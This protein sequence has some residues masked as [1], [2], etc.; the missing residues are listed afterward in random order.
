[1]KATAVYMRVSTHDQSLASQRPDVERWLAANDVEAD[2]YEDTASGCTMDRPRFKDLRGLILERKISRLVVWRLDRLGRTAAGLTAF[3]AELQ[4][5]GC[6]LVSL[7]EGIDLDTPAGRLMAHVL[8]S[9]A[10]YET[11]VRRERILAGMAAAKEAGR[12]FG[13]RKGGTYNRKTLRMRGTIVRL[14]NGRQ[15]MASVARSCG[16]GINTVRKIKR[17]EGL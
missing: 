10:A 11:E 14:L 17:E 7:R 2:V 3:F 16:V 13:G 5:H 9:V 6:T 4:A 15:S 12:T 8:A 1:M